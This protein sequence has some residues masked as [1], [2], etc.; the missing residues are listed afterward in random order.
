MEEGAPEIV[1]GE[2]FRG[3]LGRGRREGGEEE[4][5]KEGERCLVGGVIRREGEERP[6][7]PEKEREGETITDKE[8]EEESRGEREGEREEPLKRLER[9]ED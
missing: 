1:R 6:S 2:R 3:D 4:A 5:E 9:E 8:G 7:E